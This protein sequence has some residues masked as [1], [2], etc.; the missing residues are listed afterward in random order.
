M[1]RSFIDS[2]IKWIGKIPETWDI[3]KVNRIFYRR[4]EVNQDEN[5]VV[6]SL[7]RAGVKIR[8][9]STNEGQLA[10]SYDNY[11]KVYIGDL[12]LNPMDLIS[13][14]NCSI[15]EVE[16]VISPAYINLAPKKE[17][18]SKY[19]DYFFKNQYW[20]NAMFIHG[21]GVS[22]DNRWTMNA[23]TIMD[24]KIPVPPLEEQNKIAN[25]LD[26]N[27]KKIESIIIDNNEAIDLLK[28]YKDN[29]I[30]N[31][32]TSGIKKELTKESDVDWIGKIP[33][34]WKVLRGKY[35]FSMPMNS[36]NI[37]NESNKNVNMVRVEHLNYKTDLFGIEENFDKIFVNENAECIKPP[38][39][40]TPKRG[41]AIYTNKVRI[42]NSECLLDPNVMAIKT[43]QNIKYYAYVLFARKLSNIADINT[44][45]QLNNKHINSQK[46]PVPPIDEQRKIVEHL[47]NVCSKIDKIIEYRET[48]INKLEDYKKSLIYEVVTGKKEV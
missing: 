35:I 47:D 10:E 30:L 6:L 46:F 2:K 14:A 3:V 28:E 21:K 40:L 39:I 25:Y 27:C 4:K 8:D 9:I 36:Y 23:E 32:V 44:I 48:I 16:G 18:N 45:P 43:N 12:L 11:H 20:V 19:Y 24:Y 5:P 38:M 31:C 33:A 37:L 29:Y 34:D 15:S 17:C 1:S 42:I 13:G 26:K 22:F 41:G 7:A